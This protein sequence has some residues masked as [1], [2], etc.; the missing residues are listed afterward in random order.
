[1]IVLLSV[2]VLS[3]GC[4]AGEVGLIQA[5]RIVG[6]TLLILDVDCEVVRSR[7]YAGRLLYGAQVL[8]GVDLLR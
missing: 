2:G 8:H 7:V 1:M 3:A 6:V 4:A 5:H